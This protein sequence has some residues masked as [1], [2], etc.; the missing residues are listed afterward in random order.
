M[1][2]VQVVDHQYMVMSPSEA[3]MDVPD[4]TDGGTGL[5]ASSGTVA[6]I[7][8]GTSIGPI[9]VTAEVLSQAPAVAPED[10]LGHGW[11]EV[12]EVSIAAP[13]GSVGLL[14]QGGDA[15]AAPLRL[16]PGVKGPCRLRVLARG[17]D[18]ACAQTVID[19]PIEAHHLQ[20]WAAPEEPPLLLMST[21]R[22]GGVMGRRS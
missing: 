20:V 13:D 5:V 3:T 10:W 1:A 11:E 9:T 12:A 14:T 15:H 6:T 17:R 2:I 18:R 19:E 4:L 21:D 8:C 7:I 16:E 22:F